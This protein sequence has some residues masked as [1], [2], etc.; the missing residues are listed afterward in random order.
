LEE[1][2]A[3]YHASLKNYTPDMHLSLVRVY[4]DDHGLFGQVYLAWLELRS[5]EADKARAT[6]AHTIAL[7]ESFGDPFALALALAFAA[8]VYR[9]LGDVDR[10]CEISERAIALCTEQGFAYWNSLASCC[11]GWVR[12]VR[13]E[14]EEGIAEIRSGLGFADLIGQK[15]PLTYWKGYLAEAL[16]LAGRYDEGLAVV[17]E[18]LAWSA[19]NVDSFNEAE[20]LRLRGELLKLKGPAFMAESRVCFTHAIEVARSSGSTFL[21]LNAAVGLAR[22]S[23][24]R[25]ETALANVQSALDRMQGG[26]DLAVCVTA[27]RLL[28][29]RTAM[30]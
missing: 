22:A 10:T 11:H 26:A 28:A 27:K 1:A 4:G 16:L 12:A 18:A 29:S 14:I 9:D 5:G 7:A 19:A 30:R 21:E 24:G 20:L 6:V 13:G 8:L 23:A 17:D 15:L 3:A 25:D 2:R